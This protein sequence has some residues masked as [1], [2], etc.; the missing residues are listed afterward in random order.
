MYADDIR[1][2]ITGDIPNANENMM[3]DLKNI[4]Q[5][6]ELWQ[7]KLNNKKCSVL[8]I[9]SRNPNY[10]YLLNYVPITNTHEMK[11]LGIAVSDCLCFDSYIDTV[12]T[13]AYYI[14][15]GILKSFCTRSPKFL[16][17]ML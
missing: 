9:G 12:V 7:L 3:I 10:V 8:H 2:H 1:L 13:K 6:A 17:A 4:S 5:W 15:Y 11:D 14:C 16:M